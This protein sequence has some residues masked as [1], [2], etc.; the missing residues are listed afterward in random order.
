MG[1]ASPVCGGAHPRER[2]EHA[3]HDGRGEG[4][5]GLAD[6]AGGGLRCDQGKRAVHVGSDLLGLRTPVILD[7]NDLLREEV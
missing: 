3:R 1:F 4:G 6:E 2:G 5:H 7:L